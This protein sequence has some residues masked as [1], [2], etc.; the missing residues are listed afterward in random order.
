MALMCV[1]SPTIAIGQ[2]F[3]TKGTPKRDSSKY[4][5]NTNRWKDQKSKITFEKLNSAKTYEPDTSISTFHRRLFLQPWSRDLGLTGGP[6]Y[7]LFFSTDYK[8]GPTLG[9]RAFDVYRFDIDSLNY[10]NSVRPYSVFSYQ[11]VGRNENIASILHTQNL[12]PNWNFAVE[13]R[14]TSNPGYYKTQRNNHDNFALTTRYK[15]L[16]K[17]YELKSALVY[18]KQQQDEN[19]GILYDS[20]LTDPAYSDRKTLNTAYESQYSTSRSAV[21]NVLRECTFMLQHRYTFGTTD[22]TFDEEDTA[23]YS[24][25]LTPRFSITHSA[26]ISTEKHQYKDLAPD[27]M[28][29]TALFSRSF[30]NNGTGYYAPGI[31]SVYTKQNWFWADSKVLLSGYLGKAENQLRFSAGAGVRYDQFTSSPT[32]IPI[33][34]T[35]YWATGIDR[36]SRMSTFIEGS[37]RKEALDTKDWDY[38]ASLRMFTSGSYAGNFNFTA[39]IGKEISK[40]VGR[41]VAGFNQQLGSAPFSLTDYN[42]LH[43]NRTFSFDKES[44]T[45]LG[46][47]IESSKLK[48]GVGG[49]AHLIANYI[50]LN[51]NGL[52]DQYTEAFSVPQLWARKVFNVGSFYLDNE[53][54]YQTSTAGTPVNVPSLMGRH[55]LSFEKPLFGNALR[56]ATGVEC[57]Y[58]S[59][60]A[61]AGY[62][63]IYNRFFYQNT[64]AINNTPEMC[65]FVNFRVKRFR[66]FFMYDNLQQRFAKNA[67][68]FTGSP[69]VNRTN[70]NAIIPV[71]AAPNS[72][73]RFGF[74]WAMNN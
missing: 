56:L 3:P 12:K 35:P 51:A 2:T 26:T 43:T 36:H 71:Y 17:H 22:T 62:S 27:S 5:T 67:I 70:G 64:L 41:F 10:Y 11:T 59:A 16:N 25:T 39:T 33:T 46:A 1:F 54:V 57:R 37:L 63:A 69:F 21:T 66:A 4:K 9:Y 8:V 72:V 23:A 18:N 32:V 20:V 58:N 52:P 29:Y 24:Y 61:P 14:K 13:Y 65:V 68:L 34:D 7:N 6:S 55:Q 60:Y 49:R 15:S 42:N 45:T 30:A 44:I 74:S 28:R 38:G 31:D 50:F 47:G 40:T 19:G 48:M 53:L 73:F